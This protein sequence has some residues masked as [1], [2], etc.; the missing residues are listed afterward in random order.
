MKKHT[1]LIVG[2]AVW[3]LMFCSPVVA[4]NKS[5]TY[6]PVEAV[7]DAVGQEDDSRLYLLAEGSLNLTIAMASASEVVTNSYLVG[8]GAGYTLSPKFSCE[9]EAI[10]LSESLK[11]V[12]DVNA[13]MKGLSAALVYHHPMKGHLHYIP[14]LE[15]GY[16]NSSIQDYRFDCMVFDLSPFSLEYRNDNSL[17]GFRASIGQFGVAVPTFSS[18]VDIKPF[19]VVNL[20][21]VALGV[22]K[23]F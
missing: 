7:D 1:A 19:Y 18:G 9:I 10:Y 16:L 3:A 12:E 14:S 15:C 2:A 22:V 17:W 5:Q 8:L 4:A 13:R 11:S 21:R 23:Y 20:N 6:K